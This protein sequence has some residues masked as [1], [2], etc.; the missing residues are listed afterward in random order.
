MGLRGFGPACKRVDS[1]SSSSSSRA[2]VLLHV[3]PPSK[4]N[5][6]TFSRVSKRR[7]LVERTHYSTV[8][9]GSTFNVVHRI[10]PCSVRHDIAARRAMPSARALRTL[11]R[12]IHDTNDGPKRVFFFFFFETLRIVLSVLL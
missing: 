10:H 4:K 8:T 1:S 3:A 7:E 12:T 9:V 6:K 2:R 5:A 11:Q